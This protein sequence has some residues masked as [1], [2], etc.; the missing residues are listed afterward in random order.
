MY[1]VHTTPLCG[2]CDRPRL[3]YHLIPR[4]F[5]RCDTTDRAHNIVKNQQSRASLAGTRRLAT[6]GVC[7]LMTKCEQLRISFNHT[8]KETRFSGNVCIVFVHLPLTA[9]LCLLLNYNVLN[10]RHGVETS[11][12]NDDVTIANFVTQTPPLFRALDTRLHISLMALF[13]RLLTRS[14]CFSHVDPQRM[15][16]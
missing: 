5:V 7:W 11:D 8:V 10:I 2:D 3:C 4:L 14:K 13:C 12:R 15:M 1:T 16:P 9:N 6:G